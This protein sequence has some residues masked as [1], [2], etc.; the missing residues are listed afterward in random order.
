MIVQIYEIQTPEEAERCIELGVDHLGSVLLSKDDWRVKSIKEVIGL[1]RTTDAKNSLI[2][3]F[4]D[5]E[6]LYRVLDFYEPHFIHFCEN[7]TDCRGREMNLGFFVE[8]QSGL[9]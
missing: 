3:L 1:T 9:Q 6:S 5:L 2:P 7:M 4:H 8:M